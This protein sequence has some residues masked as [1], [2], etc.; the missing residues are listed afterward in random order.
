[1]EPQDESDRKRGL[2]E[3]TAM[4]V[5]E[6]WRRTE[7]VTELRRGIYTKIE[8]QEWEAEKQLRGRGNRV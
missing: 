8:V 1:M 6:R 4:E 3:K 2:F 7:R 5:T